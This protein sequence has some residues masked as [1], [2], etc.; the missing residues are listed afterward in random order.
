MTKK[1]PNIIKDVKP[2]IQ[3]SLLIP[4]KQIRVIHLGKLFS[5]FHISACL[6]GRSTNWLFSRLL[7][8]C[9]HSKQAWIIELVPHSGEKGGF[10][11]LQ[12]K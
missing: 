7:H 1:F 2:Q 8:G 4:S 9:L 5:V 12:Y 6:T 11:M 10:C 3:D